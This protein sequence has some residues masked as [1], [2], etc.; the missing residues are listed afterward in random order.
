M[1]KTSREEILERKYGSPFLKSMSEKSEAAKLY[2]ELYVESRKQARI[3]EIEAFAAYIVTII[4]L[5]ASLFAIPFLITT[6]IFLINAVHATINARIERLWAAKY[7]DNIYD[8]VRIFNLEKKVHELE[9]EYV[10]KD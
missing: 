5:V 4:C 9:A 2:Y 8:S 1:R 10:A 6:A 7:T 3:S